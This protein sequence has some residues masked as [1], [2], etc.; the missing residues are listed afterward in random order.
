METYFTAKELVYIWHKLNMAP[1]VS[2]E[3]YCANRGLPGYQIIEESH[4]AWRKFNNALKEH[5]ID[6]HSLVDY[7]DKIVAGLIT[8][9]LK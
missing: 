2:F 9:K 7:G 3:Y 4:E 5:N 1:D 8:K 6:P